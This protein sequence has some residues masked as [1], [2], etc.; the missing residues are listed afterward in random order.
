MYKQ[1]RNNTSS[2]NLSL[3]NQALFQMAEWTN[4]STA[5]SEPLCGTTKITSR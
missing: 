5:M 2:Q 1:Q 3:D 4:N